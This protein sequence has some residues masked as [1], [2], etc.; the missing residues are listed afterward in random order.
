MNDTGRQITVEIGEG[1]PQIGRQLEHQVVE[2]LA[3]LDRREYHLKVIRVLVD[4]EEKAA[5]VALVQRHAF[6]HFGCEEPL[7]NLPA[8]PLQSQVIVDYTLIYRYTTSNAQTA[9]QIIVK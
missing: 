1:L 6:D 9:N 8:L 7:V 4:V 5:L 3:A 2:H